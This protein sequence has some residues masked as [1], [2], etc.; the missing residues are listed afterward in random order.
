ME[1][2]VYYGEYSLRHWIGLILTKNIVLPPY[3][4]RFVWKE[5]ESREFI[6]SLSKKEF[7][8]PVTIGV[9]KK[10]SKDENIILDGQ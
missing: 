10:D 4:R 3:Q 5:K 7:V 2:K 1:T 6:D 9:M 8:P